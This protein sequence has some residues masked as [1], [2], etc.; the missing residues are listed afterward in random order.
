[1][2]LHGLWSAWCSF[3]NKVRGT[4]VESVHTQCGESRIMVRVR[5]ETDIARGMSRNGIEV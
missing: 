4:R 1:M 5:G 2:M 3:Y